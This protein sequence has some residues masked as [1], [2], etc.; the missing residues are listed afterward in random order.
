MR[1]SG[2]RAKAA[3]TQR[4]SRL[5]GYLPYLVFVIF[6][7]LIVAGLAFDEFASVLANAA[8]ICLSCIGIQ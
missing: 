2:T 3:G 6:A 5:R 8:T 7:A 1:A 4:A